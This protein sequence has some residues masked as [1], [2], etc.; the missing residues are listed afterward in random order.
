MDSFLKSIYKYIIL[1]PFIKIVNLLCYSYYSVLLRFN[2]VHY[3]QLPKFNGRFKLINKGKIVFG[4]QLVFNSTFSSNPM[5]LN[6]YCSVY[7]DEGAT[8]II[9]DHSGF[10]GVSIFCSKQIT[11]GRML[12]CGGNVNIWDTDFHP[13]DHR[14]RSIGD[15]SNVQSLPIIIGNDVFIGANSTIL[16]GVKIGDNS[17]IGTGSIVTKSIP[18]NQLWAGNPARYIRDNVN[19]VQSSFKGN[20]N[21]E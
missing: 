4:S 5:G 2:D 15:N 8:L 14:E 6:K 18:P 12:F 7:V 13:L 19:T 21:Y 3:K 1:Y 17:I 9:G 20:E 10:S 16:K 11:I